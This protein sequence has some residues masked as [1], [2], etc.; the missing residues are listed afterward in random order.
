[1]FTLESANLISGVAE[2]MAR[3]DIYSDKNVLD[4][5]QHIS[6]EADKESDEILANML[7]SIA[8]YMRKRAER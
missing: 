5:A 1:M 4:A 2:V 6:K 8:A 7:R 3:I